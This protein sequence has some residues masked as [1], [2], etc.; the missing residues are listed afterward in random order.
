L[1]GAVTLSWALPADGWIM[2]EAT[3][4]AGSPA[5]WGPTTAG[6]RTNAT[7]IQVTV[8]SLTGSKF[9]RLRKP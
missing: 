8:S 6:Y 5:A 4:L 2:E 9:Y 1:A 7:Q 3:T